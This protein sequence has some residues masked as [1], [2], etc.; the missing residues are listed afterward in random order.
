MTAAI[1]PARMFYLPGRIPNPNGN[2]TLTIAAWQEQPGGGRRASSAQSP[3]RRSRT[4]RTGK[5]GECDA[6]RL[7]TDDIAAAVCGPGRSRPLARRTAILSQVADLRDQQPALR[8]EENKLSAAARRVQAKIEAFRIPEG[9][10]QIRLRRDEPAPP[11]TSVCGGPGR[12][13]PGRSGS[14]RGLWRRPSRWAD[15]R[16]GHRDQA[17]DQTVVTPIH[18]ERGPG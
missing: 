16:R 17:Y 2:N 14:A 13:P 5:K 4:A 12:S 10:D 11:T 1:F 9:N 3:W 7:T 15:D 18:Y 6:W 8:T